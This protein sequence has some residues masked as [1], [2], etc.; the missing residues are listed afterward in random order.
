MPA[1]PEFILR[2]LYV[3]N[4]L[5]EQE[6]G[7]S[8]SLNNTFAPATVTAFQLKVDGHPLEPP[9]LT[10]Q[11]GGGPARQAAEVTTQ[12]PL[13]LPVNQPV[14]ITV[15]G[16]P[17]GYGQLT[18][19]VDTVEAGELQFSLSALRPAGQAAGQSPSPKL[20]PRF[21][22]LGR[23][24]GRQR[25]VL[26]I[27][28]EKQIGEINPYIYGHFIEHLET[29]IYGGIWSQ[30]GSRLRE[31]TVRLIQALQPP[32]LRYPGGNFA[33]GY[34]W[35]DGIGPPSQR[36]ARYDQA[37]NAQESNQVGTNEF[38]QLCRKVGAA[39][40][41]VVNDGSGTPEEA[42]RWVAYCNQ[43]ADG[44]QG[45]RR[46]G[47][48]Y[49]EP[50]DVRLWGIG[51]EV[52]GRWQIGHTGPGEY[53]ARLRQFSEAMRAVDPKIRIVAVGDKVSSDAYDD[54][55]RRWNDTVL[56]E[57]GDCFQYLSF[58]LYQPD[59]H[60][61][62]EHYDPG[63]LHK[64]VCAAPLSAE[65]MIT[66][67]SEQ[68]QRSAPGKGIK[69]AFD[70]WNLWLPPPPEAAS[71]HQVRYTLRDALY[72]AGMLNVFQRQSRSLAIATLAQLVNV[73]PLIVTNSDQAYATPLYYPFWMYRQMEP[74]ALQV[75][76]DSPAYDSPALGNIDVIQKV[77]YIDAS[78]TCSRSR[79]RVVIG[80]VNRHP[81]RR[82]DLSVRLYGFGPLGPRRGWL[83][84]GP[85][86]LA[87]NSFEQP[88]AVKAKEVELRSI[89][90]RTRFTL[91]LPACSVSTIVLEE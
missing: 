38:I 39:P 46:A 1:V 10:L 13:P 47:H 80:I 31:D 52:W 41:L 35:E 78:A 79:R 69:I 22:L 83:L 7:F 84:S 72:V 44:D 71:M 30:D 45:R 14:R 91:D 74:V 70:E 73:L 37:W 75:E 12:S 65:R 17:I 16:T 55:G 64:I 6:N 40:F 87:A 26:R 86:P 34:H 57:A 76:L 49:P 89:G 59:Q 51:N 19:L 11:V 32:L 68:I 53:A 5:L 42:A 9:N 21:D 29:C 82:V 88:E 25:A 90:Q 50:H 33:S 23:L 24:L 36:P 66:R 56:R 58:H 63:L 85:D 67:L 2:K 81:T 62:Q 18:F 60:G 27:D 61:W 3:K 4:S 77:P 28:A 54:P 20:A 15:T 48:G 8:F 43:D